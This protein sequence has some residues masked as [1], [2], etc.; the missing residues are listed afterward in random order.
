MKEPLLKEIFMSWFS[1]NQRKFIF[2]PGLINVS[3]TYDRAELW[4]SGNFTTNL[5]F[6]MDE[7]F[8]IA[9]HDNY[10]HQF[11]DILAEFDV[12][13]K[14]QN[15]AN[16]TADYANQSIKHSIHLDQN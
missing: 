3:K 2:C 6:R 4:L 13:E 7:Q 12:Y 9:L 16:T 14:K 15:W 5:V 11:W 10:D 1:H 8:H